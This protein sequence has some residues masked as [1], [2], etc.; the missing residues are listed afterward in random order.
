ME[1]RGSDLI[2]IARHPSGNG[3][4]LTTSVVLPAA[5][6]ELFAFFSDARQLEAITPPWLNFRVLDPD[7]IVLR[8]GTLINY[9][10]RILGIPL[11]WQS[12]ISV[13][14]PN[15][16]FVDEQVVGPYRWWRHEHRFTDTPMAGP[17]GERVQGT[18]ITDT[19]EYG[20]PLAWVL[21]PLLVRRDLLAIFAHRRQRM[22]ELFPPR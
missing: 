18:E 20:V 13:W 4:R 2:H 10:L 12:R 7:G 8:E 9:R 11:R 19:V 21:H 16:R 3:F 5:R 1:Q 14:Q 22:L 17:A 6:D 15:E